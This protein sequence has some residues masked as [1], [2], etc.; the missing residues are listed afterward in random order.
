MFDRQLAAHMDVEDEHSDR[1]RCRR[2]HK[3]RD[4]RIGRKNEN[5]RELVA[6]ADQRLV[7][8]A[9]IY[10]VDAQ[11]WCREGRAWQTRS[12]ATVDQLI[13]QM[14]LSFSKFFHKN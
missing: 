7:E 9:R 8:I 1:S 13:P 14:S 6:L 10:E 12:H 3:D 11:V 2:R 4:E 5:M